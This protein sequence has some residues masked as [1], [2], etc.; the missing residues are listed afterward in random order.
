[1][2]DQEKED[3]LEDQEIPDNI[4]LNKPELIEEDQK[5]EDKDYS[6]ESVE[7]IDNE[8]L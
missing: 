5:S 1:M 7:D 2:E 6:E 8:E 3:N 4:P